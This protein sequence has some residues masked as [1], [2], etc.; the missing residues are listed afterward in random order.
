MRRECTWLIGKCGREWDHRHHG[1]C[2]VA[3]RAG[4]IKLRLAQHR[5][6]DLKLLVPREISGTNSLDGLDLLAGGVKK[7]KSRCLICARL[8]IPGWKVGCLSQRPCQAR[9]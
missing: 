2:S 9:R 5:N 8:S 6:H 1:Q 4:K 3:D 7:L